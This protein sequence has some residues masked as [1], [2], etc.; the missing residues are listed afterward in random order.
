MN[1]YPP[2]RDGEISFSFKQQNESFLE[3]NDSV[4]LMLLQCFSIYI[5][6]IQNEKLE[7]SGA[8]VE[9]IVEIL[10]QQIVTQLFLRVC[11]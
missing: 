5:L 4:F 8:L 2:R 1:V 7:K 10:T 11:D 9:E 6:D 3:R